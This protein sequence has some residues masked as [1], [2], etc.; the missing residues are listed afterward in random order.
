MN[1]GA[2]KALGDYLLF[3]NDDIEV[4]TPDWIESMLEY[5]QQPEIGAV[6]AKLLFPDGRL[7]HVGVTILDRNPGH[8]FYGTAGENLGYFCGNVVARNYSSVT[9]ACLMTR[10]DVFQES[11][12]FTEALPLNYND[13]DLCLRIRDLGLR[14][15]YVPYAT[16]YHHE[17]A[18]KE[19]VHESE[20]EAFRALW[21]NKLARDPYYNSNLTALHGDFRVAGK[22]EP[23]A[24]G[25][26]GR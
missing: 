8:P 1:L 15:V 3:L 17:S 5:A 21:G 20:L 2:A 26:G 13:V 9:G 22:S 14:I 7:Q 25:G 11:G 6:G 4:I 10:A 16:L 12:G 23:L 18:S 24:P 19:G